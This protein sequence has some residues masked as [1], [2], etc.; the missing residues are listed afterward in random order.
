MV[1]PKE[2]RVLLRHP[3]RLGRGSRRPG[4]IQTTVVLTARNKIESAKFVCGRLPSQ[5]DDVDRIFNAVYGGARDFRRQPKQRV[6]VPDDRKSARDSAQL[7]IVVGNKGSP[8]AS[9]LAQLDRK[10]AVSALDP[11][12]LSRK[13]N[14]DQR[15]KRPPIQIENSVSVKVFAQDVKSSVAV[16][17]FA[18]VERSITVGVFGFE[19]KNS[20]AVDVLA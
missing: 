2:A 4:P 16:D 12:A 3:P 13:E 15:V 19:I 18:G 9:G 11:A 5:C 14:A 6:F 7:G 8:H 20:I 1:S 10:V 17:V